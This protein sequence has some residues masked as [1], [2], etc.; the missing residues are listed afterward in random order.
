[1]PILVPPAMPAPAAARA[2]CPAVL[3]ATWAGPEMTL[4]LAGGFGPAIG[5]GP[6]GER[7]RAASELRVVDGHL[8]VAQDDSA[9]AAVSPLAGGPGRLRLL[10]PELA[11]R[12]GRGAVPKAGK[13]DVE[14]FVKV[15]TKQGPRLLAMGSGSAP[16]RTRVALIDPAGGPET[17]RVATLAGMYATLAARTDLVGTELNL[18]GAANLEDVLRLFQ[19]GNG[20]ERDGRRPRNAS[21]DLDLAGFLSY[22]DRALVDP[23]APF[24][25]KLLRFAAVYD[26]GE[27]RGG[28]LTFSGACELGGGWCVYVAAAELSPDAVADGDI[29]GSAV[30]LIDRQGRAFQTPLVL[31]D[32]SV[33]ALKLEGVAL[34]GPDAGGLELLLCADQ[35][36]PGHPS[37]ILRARLQGPLVLRVLAEAFRFDQRQPSSTARQ[38][39]RHTRGRSPR[40][41]RAGHRR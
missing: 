27:L 24:D 3:R 32:G 1:M 21:I 13:A 2:G 19:R 28:R 34:A 39:E 40:T 10:F 6:G 23:G 4:G 5:S 20:A 11:A 38:A 26:L 16:G 17:T 36:Q 35:D 8:W 14:C 18:E 31:P 22:L 7:A 9:Y 37:P 29:A 12:F 30:G 25:G 33:P 41:P 15:E